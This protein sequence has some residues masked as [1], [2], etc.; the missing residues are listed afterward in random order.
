MA[1][2]SEIEVG[3][4]AFARGGEEEFGA[5][6]AVGPDAILVYV[7]DAGELR[8]PAEAVETVV[9]QKVIIDVDRLGD[10]AQKAIAQAHRDEDYP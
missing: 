9:E 8:V 5:V 7:E 3:Y 2:L 10:A 4:H 1:T 6:R